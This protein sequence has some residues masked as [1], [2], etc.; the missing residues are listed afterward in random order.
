[1]TL[2]GLQVLEGMAGRAGFPDPVKTL[3]NWRYACSLTPWPIR[4]REFLDLT[5]ASPNR[6]LSSRV[7]A[8]NKAL[9]RRLSRL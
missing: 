4:L 8:N 7:L 9:L 6:P 3:M 1:M 2:T 5:L